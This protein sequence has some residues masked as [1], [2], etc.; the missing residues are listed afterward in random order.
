M[1]SPDRARTA[2]AICATDG[3]LLAMTEDC[4]TTEA[5]PGR[6]PGGERARAA[7]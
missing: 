4:A 5:L 2:T 1:F 6:W 7:A 3:G